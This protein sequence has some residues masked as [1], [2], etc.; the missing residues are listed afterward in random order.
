MPIAKQNIKT[1]IAMYA[2][3]NRFIIPAILS[4]SSSYTGL[5]KQ[6]ATELPIPSSV[7]DRML[8]IFVNVPFKPNISSPR[9][10]IKIVLETKPSIM[11]TNCEI[12]LDVPFKNENHLRILISKIII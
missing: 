4:L 5:Y 10:L 6:Y 7:I 3:L 11:I 9:Q 12:K 8:K 1:P 2:C